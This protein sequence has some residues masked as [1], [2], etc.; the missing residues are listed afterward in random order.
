VPL[1]TWA[2]LVEVFGAVDVAERPGPD[3]AGAEGVGF[4]GGPH[5]L[6]SFDDDCKTLVLVMIEYIIL[7]YINASCQL[8]CAPK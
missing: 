5:P 6:L 3:A 4:G 2:V 8:P 1:A 7:T